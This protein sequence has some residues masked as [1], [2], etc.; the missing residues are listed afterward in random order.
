MILV[1]GADG[2]VGRHLIARLAGEGERPLALVRDVPRA[3]RVL[4]EQGVTIVEGDTTRYVTLARALEDA[5]V[6][7]IV[8]S[9]FVTA[10]RK[11]KTGTNYYQTNVLGT[12]NLVAAAK[13]AGVKRIVV[14][15]GLGT[16]PDKPRSYMQGRFEADQAV[17]NSGLAYSILGPSVQFGA[18]SAFFTGLAALIKSPL[19]F[20]PMIGSGHLK[21]QPI[22]VED[23]VTCL[24]KMIREPE[25]YDGRYLQVG[26]PEIY[27][28]AAI[29]DLLMRRLRKKKLKLPG[30]VPL[31]ALGAAMM[32]FTLSNP[33]ITRAT[34]G[35]FD[36]DNVTARDAVVRDFG[37][38]P[39][40]LPD[41]LAAHGVE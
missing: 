15:G 14:M 39:L 28:Y 19:P 8:H 18:G 35:L 32:E 1:T 13:E 23:V 4:P 22:W 30:P 11:Q 12:R 6:D 5:S 2:F 16:K 38:G 29:L 3:R 36:F 21:F 7:T 10:N 24:C 41:Y 20:V 25:R 37:F 27:T 40:S 33:P 34:L 31:A 9:A 17:K 26:G